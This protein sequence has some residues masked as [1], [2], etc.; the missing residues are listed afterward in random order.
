MNQPVLGQWY[1]LDPNEVSSLLFETVLLLNL[2][3]Q[4]WMGYK[5][6]FTYTLNSNEK[7]LI[8][9]NAYTLAIN[10]NVRISKAAAG[11]NSVCSTFKRA[12]SKQTSSPKE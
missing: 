7:G 3:H 11:K 10:L 8:G 6:Q 4:L 5:H 2:H 1:R 9:K 12:L